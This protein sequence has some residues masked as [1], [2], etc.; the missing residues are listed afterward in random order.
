MAE[1]LRDLV[2]SLS[3]NT[4]NFTRNIKSVGKQIQEAESYFKLAAAG[5]DSFENTTEGLT[6]RLS[7][8][9]RRLSLQKDVVTQYERALAQA[10]SKLTEC[11]N[12]QT[13]YAQRLEKA[14]QRQT[15][16]STEVQNAS[17]AY[18]RYRDSLGE[19]DSA[20]IAAKAN[21]EA[22]Q[23]EYEAACNEVK[24][25]AG[26]QDALRKATQNAADAVSTQQ[27]HLNKAQASVRE[28]ER[29]IRG[30]N[31]A[32]RLSQTNWQA[33]GDRMKAVDAAVTSLGK[34]MQLAQSRFRLASAGIKDV[35]TNAGA[36]SAKLVML[37]EKLV[38]GQRTAAQYAEKLQAAREQLV[39]AQA[40]NDPEKIRAATDA[41]T[42]AETALTNA[43]ASVRETEAAIRE[44]NRQL[45]TARSLWTAAGKSLSDFSVH[46]ESVSKTTGAIGRTLSAMVT[47][48][49]MAL[50]A[51]AIKSSIEF[52]SAFTGVRKTVD[53][54]EAEFSRLEDTVKRMSTEIAT[55]TTEIAN[56]MATAGQL[57]IRNDALEDFT[58]VM[59]DL[60]NSTDIVSEEA[61]S[62]LAKFANIMDMDQ[63][64]FQNLGSTLVDLGNNFATTESAIMEMALRLAGA[65]KQ[66]GLS[67]AQILGFATALSAVGIEAQMGGS[68]LSK[69]LVKMEVAAATGGE[70]LTDFA[71]ICGMT[72]E[73][74][75]QIWNADPAVVFQAFIQNLARMD[76]EGISAIAVLNDIGIAEVRL[77]DTLLRSVNATELF[78][79]TQETANRAWEENTALAEEAGKRYATTQSRLINLKNKSVLFAQQLGDDLNPTIHSLIDGVDELMDRFMAL[80]ESQRKQIIQTVAFAASIGPAFLAVSKLTKGLSAITGGIGKFAT[81]VGK[82]GGGFGGFISVLAKSPAVWLAVAAAVVAGTVALVDY[83]SGAKQAHEALEGMNET[84][85]KWKDIAAETFYNQS[86]GLSFFGMSAEDFRTAGSDIAESGAAWLSGLIAVWTDGKRETNDIVTEWT[87][88]FKAGTEEIR[89]ALSQMQVTA[90]QNGYTSLSEQMKADL[91]TLDSVDAEISALLKKRQSR[92]FTGEDKV[93]LEELIDTREAIQVKYNLVPDT[94]NTEGFDTIRRKLE[95]EVARAQARGQDD[96]SVTVYENAMVAAAQGMAAINAQIDENYDKEYALIQLIEDSAEREAALSDLNQRYTAERR[97]AALEYAQLMQDIVLPV[98]SH[99]EIQQASSD[100]D[101]LAAKLAQFSTATESEKPA[102]L[103]ELN[104]ISAGMDEDS[105]IEYIG[106]LTQ[107]QSLLDSGVTEEE[108]QSLFPE[109]DFSSALDQIAAIQSFLNGRES[110]LPGLASIFSEAVPDEMVIMATDLDMTGAQARWDEFAAN[111]GAI[112]T[113][114]IISGYADA[115]DGS[116]PELVVEAMISAYTEIPE[117]ADRSQLTLEGL[118]AYVEKYAEVTG[119]ADVSALTP[120]I[121]AAFVSGYRELAAGADVSQLTPSEIVAYV[122]S[123]AEKESVDI[124]ALKPDAVTAFVM[125]YEE[126]SGGAMTTALTPTDIAAIVTEYLLAENVDLSAITDAQV[127][128]IVNAYAEAVNCDKSALKA[129]VVAQI[130]AYEEAEGVT[131]PSFINTQVSITGYDLTAY[132]QFVQENPVEVAG[133]VRLG[134]VYDSPEE[135]L[136]DGNSRFYQGGVEVPAEMVT[137]EMLTADKVAV[138]DEDGTMHILLTPEL[139]GDQEVIEQ[140]RTEIAEVDSLGVTELGKAAGILPTTIMDRVNSA[141][142]R[143]KS[144]E[145]TQDYN[146]LQKFWAT[147]MGESTD[148][149][150]LDQ[151]MHLDFDPDT[152]ATMTT[153]ISEMVTAIRNGDEIAA[154]DYANLQAIVELINGLEVAG[155]GENVTAGIGEAMAAAGWETDAESVASNL[156]NALNAALVIHSP[157]QRMHPIGENIAAGIGQGAAGYDFGADAATISSALETALLTAMGANPLTTAGTAAMTGLA[158]AMTSFSMSGTARTVSTN[159]RNAASS[160]L[161][162]STLRSVGVNAMAG[163]TAGITAGRSGVISAMRSAARAAV[164]AAKSELK[165]ASP[166]RVFRDEVGAM[167]MKGFGEGVL[168][169]SRAQARIIRNAARFLTDEAREGAIVNN[170]TTQNRTYNQ[171]SSVTLTGNTF[172][173]RDEQDIYALANEIAALTRRQQR[174]KGLRM[175]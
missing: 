93:R 97:Q 132:R 10:T 171:Q 143:L 69:A 41:I 164:S 168:T 8:L 116:K 146:W 66:V 50:G 39:A 112:T 110:M 73:Q 18:E 161:N 157:S 83:A 71:T 29:A 169:E 113:D 126:A 53:A 96:A 155:V 12:R 172:T 19:S 6:A 162:T 82:A 86:E 24:Q 81:A 127:D 15:A 150:V 170:T 119:G 123:Y 147:L 17:S 111:P 156:E 175:A 54:S 58:R 21:M 118:V 109:I 120:E 55:D 148:K 139:T 159:V 95:A 5:V 173:I 152:L 163:L 32:L 92:L 145:K 128:A 149:G 94:E 51:T 35:D 166:S 57:G 26:Q 174:G 11:Y 36:L 153:Y 154:E 136:L 80:D 117:G 34:Q 160:S 3:L 78:S 134:G 22:A 23:Q 62:T 151:S 91:D 84:A 85:Q 106:L 122:S 72:E 141:V 108:A 115:E 7:M 124:S 77:R 45:D 25:L 137:S 60:G 14:R 2:V 101:T 133:I 142:N 98:W 49:V 43:Q 131:L 87:E 38:L 99:E 63:S 64:L 104:Q 1:S 4:E 105:L 140:L 44:T 9:E 74:F 135:A 59:I 76:E 56:V 13:D 79:A 125:A 114:A 121:A 100:I 16:L 28:T 52:E 70:A 88:S 102:L 40:A 144:F 33:A 37:N 158:G 107:I 61:G 30:C 89:T 42:D 31:D 48:P 129:E 65:G 46:C 75:V 67:E 27:T 165:I 103:E 68:A 47:A 167:T 20:T 90:D 138:L 130:T